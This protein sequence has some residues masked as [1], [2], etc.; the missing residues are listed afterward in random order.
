MN[1]IMEIVCFVCNSVKDKSKHGVSFQNLLTMLR[2]EFRE[3]DFD[4]K[5][6]SIVKKTRQF[7]VK[8]EFNLRFYRFCEK[9]K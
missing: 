9:N 5:I 6:K 8:K 1:S 3:Q 4:L 2:R 7:K